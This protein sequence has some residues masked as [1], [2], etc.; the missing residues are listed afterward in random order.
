MLLN[1][2][3]V[4]LNGAIT[5]LSANQPPNS[6]AGM[7]EH[8]RRLDPGNAHRFAVAMQRDAAW[9]NPAWGEYWA[10]IVRLI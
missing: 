8:L 4:A 7:A 5:D 10:E 9:A 3:E 2:A 6:A 1:Q